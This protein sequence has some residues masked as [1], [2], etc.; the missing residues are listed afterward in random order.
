MF[1]SDSV[2]FMS[3]SSMKRNEETGLY[4]ADYMISISCFPMK[5]LAYEGAI[6]VPYI[7]K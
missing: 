3:T 2:R 5:M 7:Q 6:I 4:G 1:S